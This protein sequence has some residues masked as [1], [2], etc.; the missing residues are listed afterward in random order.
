[1]PRRKFVSNSNEAL[2][3]ARQLELEFTEAVAE[4]SRIWIALM[5]LVCLKGFRER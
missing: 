3:Y 2:D 1:M 4:R 5:S